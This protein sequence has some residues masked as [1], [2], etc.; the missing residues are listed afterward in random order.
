[1][2]VGK[3]GITD[4]VVQAVDQAIEAHELIKVKFVD[5]KDEKDAIC[6]EIAARTG[7]VL[8]GVL[9]NVATFYRRQPDNEKRRIDLAL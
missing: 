3:S 8:V 1:M 2:Q 4:H 6:T 5:H 7:S 9:G